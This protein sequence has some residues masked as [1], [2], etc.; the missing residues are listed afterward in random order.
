M[1]IDPEALRL[2]KAEGFAPPSADVPRWS[3][4]VNARA[5]LQVVDDE[6][7]ASD[8][9][10]GGHDVG[11]GDD[12]ASNGRGPPDADHLYLPAGLARHALGDANDLGLAVHARLNGP[13]V[14]ALDF[15]GH[16][17]ETNDVG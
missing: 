9:R 4:R 15:Q 12:D 1:R 11:V 14:A 10:S 13:P 16:L 2:V 8:Q 17:G 7:P 6:S 3:E 5:A